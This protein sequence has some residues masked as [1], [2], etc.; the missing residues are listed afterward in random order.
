MEIRFVSTLTAE[1]EARLARMVAQTIGTW[2]DE[3]PL[4]YTL[5]ITT[6]SGVVTTR[7][8][9]K[10]DPALHDPAFRGDAVDAQPL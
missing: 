4:L 9:A 1:D 6:S 3:L 2:L 10:G 7:Q 5:Q 8:S